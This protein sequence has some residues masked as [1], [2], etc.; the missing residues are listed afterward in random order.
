MNKAFDTEA[1]D[2]SARLSKPRPSK[3]T[4][5]YKGLRFPFL[6]KRPQTASMSLNHPQIT[7]LKSALK[8]PIQRHQLLQQPL[9]LEE[10][11][12]HIPT[13]QWLFQQATQPHRSKSLKVRLLIIEIMQAS[14]QIAPAPDDTIALTWI[15]F[16]THF[17]TYD[18]QQLSFTDWFNQRLPPI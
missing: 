11:Q 8:D 16:G 3:Q 4:F 7:L 13:R 12:Q 18:P 15:W 17:T 6:L 14:G 2:T 1:F 10:I 5:I 9:L